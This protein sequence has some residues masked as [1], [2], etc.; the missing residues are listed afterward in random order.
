MQI[1]NKAKIE[2]IETDFYCCV[3]GNTMYFEQGKTCI[4]SAY[5]QIDIEDENGF[6][7]KYYVI[8][9]YEH[10]SVTDDTVEEIMFCN[11]SYAYDSS[12]ELKAECFTLLNKYVFTTEIEY[13]KKLMKLIKKYPL[14]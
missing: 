4:D 11:Y 3:D 7:I 6:A 9:E 1:K 13:T 14:R 8:C 2:Q 12:D 10:K 5:Y